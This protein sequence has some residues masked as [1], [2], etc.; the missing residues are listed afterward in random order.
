MTAETGTAAS[1][2]P[3][4]HAKS[5]NDVLREQGVDPEQ[6][7]TAAE[8]TARRTT[9][10]ANRFAEQTPEPRLRAFL[11]QY[12]DAMQIVLL[13]A[14]ILTIYPVKQVSTGVLLI[15]LTVLNACLGLSQE[16]KAAAAVAALQKMMVVKA[17]VRREDAAGRAAGGGRRGGGSGGGMTPLSAQA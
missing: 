10:G 3:A 6:G 17:R 11:R 13:V 16:G 7:L 15:L 14:G 5:T 1:T 8:V 9:F 2:P 4:W 12:A